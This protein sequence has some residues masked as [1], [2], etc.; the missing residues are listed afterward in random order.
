MT[1]A[2]AEPGFAQIFTYGGG[3]E[4]EAHLRVRK[5]GHRL[6]P[7]IIFQFQQFMYQQNPYAKVFKSASE[8]CAEENV[9]TLRIKTVLA[10]GSDHRRYNLPTANE[11]AA[12]IDGDGRVGGRQRDIVL[13]RQSGERQ[14]ISKLHTGYFALRYPL[15]FLYGSQM[16]SHSF[17]N[18]TP[19]SKFFP[20]SER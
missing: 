3:G 4:A 9:R 18:P 20:R 5:S 1:P 15:L 13:V 10:P 14:S 16:W 11:V 7:E 6:D 19:T 8:I 2:G 17:P 12:I